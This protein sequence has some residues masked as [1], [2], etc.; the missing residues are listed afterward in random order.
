MCVAATALAQQRPILF[1]AP[2]ADGKPDV[3]SVHGDGSGFTVIAPHPAVD[4]QPAWSPDGLWIAFASKRSG[5]FELFVTDHAGV[6]LRPLNTPAPSPS[7]ALGAPDFSPDGRVLAY[8]VVDGDQR[9]VWTVNVDGTH[10]VNLTRGQGRNSRPDWLPDG[11]G[12]VFESDR[13]GER[14]LYRMDPDGSHI[15][16][17]L[18]G[19]HPAVSPD[20]ARVAFSHEGR[21]FVADMNG[22]H[23]EMIA[24]EA[25]QPFWSPSGDRI[26]FVRRDGDRIALFL[27]SPDGHDQQLV[28]LPYDRVNHPNWQ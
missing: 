15:T 17:L 5:S 28:P 24:T 7:A 12:I 23:P 13:A 6:D 11:S 20:G 1:E 21:V 19:A 2:G 10:V 25:A 9:D 26:G 14:A 8:H 22:D 16:R 4:G 3:Y 18:P 27:A